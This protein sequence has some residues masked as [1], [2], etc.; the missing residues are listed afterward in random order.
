[1]SKIGPITAL[2]EEDVKR[3]L[4][5]RGIVVWL[6]KHAVY[7]EYVDSLA[8]RY[9]AK[10]FPFPVVSFRG[11]FLEMMFAL[12]GYENGLDQEPILIHMPGHTEESVRKTP[13]LEL[14]SSGYRYRRALDTLIREAATGRTEPDKIEAFLNSDEGK[15]L[16]SADAWLKEASINAKEGLTGFLES[17]TLEWVVEGLLCN[18]K[19]LQEKFFDKESLS[20]LIDHLYR[21]TGLNTDFIYFYS[22]SD[23]PSFSDTGDIFAAWLMCVEYVHDLKRSPYLGHLNSIK[24]LSDPLR[25]TCIRLVTYLRDTHPNVYILYA[26]LTESHLEE[27]LEAI[28]PE[29]LG[30]VDTFKKEEERILEGAVRALLNENWIQALN[31]ADVRLG[32]GSFWLKQEPT[33]RLVWTLV[34]D[35]AKLGEELEKSSHPLKKL[36]NL[37]AALDYYTS[38]GY[39]VDKAHRWFEQQRLNLLDSKLPH[40]TQLLAAADLLRQLY[41]KWADALGIDFADIC[42]KD[43]FTPQSHLQQRNLYD[44]IV[45]PLIQQNE[46]VAYFL[47]DAFRFEMAAEL[48]KDLEGPGTT[49]NLK[50]RYCE[51]PSVTSVGMNVLAPV[52]KNGKLV[53]AGGTGFNGF[54]T[55]EYTVHKP[56]ERIRAMGD[57]S[58]DNISSGRKKARGFPIN[59]ICN[60]SSASLKKGITGSNLIVVYGKEIDDAGEANV[61]LASFETWLR[62]IKTAWTQLKNIGISE[63]VFSADHGFLLQDQTT[64]EK[65]YGSKRDPNRRYVLSTEPRREEGMTNVSLSSLGYEGQ[66]GY[67]LFRKDTAIFATGKP[68]A[69][70]VHG[71]NSLQERIIPVLT[72]SHRFAPTVSD[73]SYVIKAEVLPEILGYSRIRVSVGVAANSQLNIAGTQS[74]N[75]SLRVAE[76]SDVKVSIKEAGGVNLNNQVFGVL[77]DNKPVEVLFDLSGPRDERVRLEVFHPDGVENVIPEIVNTYFNVAGTVQDDES[78]GRDVSAD[79]QTWSNNFEDEA[80]GTVFMH[81]DE[82][83]SITESELNQILGSPR[84]V[85]KFALSFE[86]HLSKVPFS[87]KIETHNSGKRYVKE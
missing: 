39:Q 83:G 42:D 59:D 76:R 63:F 25:K 29:D 44:Q 46:K 20:I 43:G 62:Q 3:E 40:F 24:T 65:P 41:R 55:G 49:V 84:K 19:K 5:Q 82:H 71:G 2:L 6:D 81:L 73:S 32:S 61:G 68:R 57:K 70:F 53:L 21:H 80:V 78:A 35:A 56:D 1:M 72:V 33:R 64:K 38:E 48:V 86:T 30:Q 11:S 79:D 7:S 27:E 66:E 4:R 37:E 15:K 8:E 75:L 26:E 51:L 74:I 54:K 31:W 14:Y 85:R 28:A 50:G 13:V 12:E 34:A 18:E 16:E 87:V 69:T 22:S 17:L 52:V 45:H 77:V 47:I 60:R 67:L 9:M 23:E 36:K 10:D 58:L